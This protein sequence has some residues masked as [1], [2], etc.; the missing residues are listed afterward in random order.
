MRNKITI[1]IT[2]YSKTLKRKPNPLRILLNSLRDLNSEEFRV[3]ILNTTDPPDTSVEEMIGRM[4]KDYERHLK[5]MYC[6]IL[7]LWKIHE[8]LE[9]NGF[10][11]MVSD[12]S[13]KGYANFRNFGLIVAR[14][15]KSKFVLM[16]DDD[17]IVNERDFLKR[18]KDGMG[19]RMN[20]K[21]LYGKTGY[22]VYRDEMYKLKPKGVR[23]RKMWPAIQN[24]NQVLENAVESKRRFN[25]AQIALGG[26][27]FLHE[28]LYTKIPFDPE[29]PRGED[30]DYLMNARQWGFRFVIDNQFRILHCPLRNKIDFWEQLRQDIYRFVYVREKLSYFNNINVKDF[31]PYPGVFLK[32]DLEYRATVTSINYATRALKRNQK[33]YFREHMRNIEIT[34]KDAKEHAVRNAHKYFRFQKRWQEMMRIV[35]NSND[36]YKFFYRF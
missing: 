2:T 35:P 8:F 10:S 33:K 25:E 20:G 13:F 12:I 22:Y 7:D 32:R 36:L 31:E 30:T 17:E 11:D 24:I 3:I 28:K 16:L 26:L 9:N 29:V 5:I 6:S 27:M 19:N 1:L 21:R 4:R 23:R 18:V 34:F 14:I 15:L